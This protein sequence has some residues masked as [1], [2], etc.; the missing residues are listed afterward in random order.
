MGYYDFLCVARSTSRRE[1]YLDVYHKGLYMCIHQRLA[2]AGNR[3]LQDIYPHLAVTIISHFFLHTKPKE[4]I[5]NVPSRPVAQTKHTISQHNA[6]RIL[7]FSMLDST[8]LPTFITAFH[9]AGTNTWYLSTKLCGI[10]I[11]TSERC[12]LHVIWNVPQ[13]VERIKCSAVITIQGTQEKCWLAIYISSALREQS[14][15]QNTYHCFA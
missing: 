14:R 3:S 5:H 2:V 13:T 9:R 11:L 7:L 4:L 1:H 6:L 12:P 15:M 10:E 8:F